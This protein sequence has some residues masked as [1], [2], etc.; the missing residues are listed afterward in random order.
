MTLAV[1]YALPETI[2]DRQPEH[3]MQDDDDFCDRPLA[4]PTLDAII[5]RRISRRTLLKGGLAASAALA[6]VSLVASAVEAAVGRG[7]TVELWA[8]KPSAPG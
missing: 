2:T 3:A 1:C 4:S 5:S 8:R 6:T 7:G